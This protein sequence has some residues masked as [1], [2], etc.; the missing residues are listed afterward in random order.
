ML[1]DYKDLIKEKFDVGTFTALQIYEEI[2]VNGYEGSYSTV[3]RHLSKLV[4]EK[5]RAFKK[6]SRTK[7][8]RNEKHVAWVLSLLQGGKKKTVLIH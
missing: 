1:D 8:K 5:E 3:R 4:K 2:R 6:S 7:E